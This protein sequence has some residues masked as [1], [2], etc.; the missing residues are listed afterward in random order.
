[1]DVTC[2]KSPEF[3]K[4]SKLALHYCCQH[5]KLICTVV[6]AAVKQREEQRA[7]PTP[8]K[9]VYSQEYTGKVYSS[10]QREEQREEKEKL[11][12]SSKSYTTVVL[13]ETTATS[14]DAS[15][16]AAASAILLLSRVHL[17]EKIIVHRITG[18]AQNH[19]IYGVQQQQ[20]HQLFTESQMPEHIV[21]C[22]GQNDSIATQ[23]SKYMI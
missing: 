13:H 3:P 22:Q 1:M 18:C 6:V 19:N 17:N 10:R 20:H 23:L 21:S 5:D 14:T 2:K 15:L 7:I 16:T 9:K 11:N 8:G 12:S 4:G